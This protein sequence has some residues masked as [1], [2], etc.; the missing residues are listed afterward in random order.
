MDTR[1][2]LF[3]LSKKYPIITTQQSHACILRFLLNIH[4]LASLTKLEVDC[5]SH[6]QAIRFKTTLAEIESLYLFPKLAHYALPVPYLNILCTV[7]NKTWMPNFRLH[8]SLI[9][10][11]HFQAR[12]RS[13]KRSRKQDPTEINGLDV[14]VHNP[15]DGKPRPALGMSEN[16]KLVKL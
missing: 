3:F 7:F 9:I 8:T 10:H 5:L 16:C 14:Y 15:C 13:S 12:S 6:R 11:V 4:V 1:L 2:K